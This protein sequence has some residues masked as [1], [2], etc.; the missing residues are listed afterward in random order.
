MTQP[1]WLQACD[2]A[3]NI[4]TFH[5]LGQGVY[6]YEQGTGEVSLVDKETLINLIRQRYE[7]GTNE[8]G[9]GPVDRA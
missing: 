5:W 3:T 7:G 9:G 4:M 6:A 2:K 8:V 1:D